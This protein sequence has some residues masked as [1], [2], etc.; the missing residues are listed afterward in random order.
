V[1][2]TFNGKFKQTRTLGVSETNNFLSNNVF[3]IVRACRSLYPVN[4]V[5]LLLSSSFSYKASLNKDQEPASRLEV[6][7][8]CD[9]KLF[10]GD[11]R[12]RVAGWI[13]EYPDWSLLCILADGAP[14][15][16]LLC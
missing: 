14:E 2:T 15:R 11:V 12:S 10:Y 3:K 4:S 8:Y 6:M 7:H 1:E 5:A 9:V 13:L 16:P